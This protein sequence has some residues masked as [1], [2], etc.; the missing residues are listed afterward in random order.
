MTHD[1]ALRARAIAH[2]AMVYPYKIWGFG[3]SIALEAIWHAASVLNE[4]AYKT[5]VLEML[6]RW[7]QRRPVLQEADHSASGQML[8]EAF[9]FTGDRRYLKL[10]EELAAYLSSLPRHPS[11]ALFHRPQHPEYRS[12]LYVDCMEVDAPFLCSLAGVTG[13]STYFDRAAEQLLAYSSLLQDPETGLFYHHYDGSAGTANGA[14]WGRGNGWAMLGLLK[15][16]LRLPLDHPKRDGIYERFT[17]LA[18]ALARYQLPEGGWATV[19]TMAD[20]YPEAS[21]PAFFS[22]T[23]R[24]AVR[25][26]LLGHRYSEVADKAG[27]ALERRV[28]NDGLLLGVS[29]ATPPGNAVHYNNIET[30]AGFPWGQGPALLAY[31]SRLDSH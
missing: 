27:L 14:F 26:G 18:E 15:T 6:A 19:I 28:S 8:V 24:T 4:T 1:V 12:F 13:N 21:L 5:W 29:V 2:Q 25:G 3:E 16:L 20:T 30:G 23:F 22:Y 31:L 11:G 17:R 9:M 10:A 7:L